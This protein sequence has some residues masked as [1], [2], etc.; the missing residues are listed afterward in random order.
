MDPRDAVSLSLDT[1]GRAVLFAGLIVVIALLG[2]F[3]MDLDFVRAVSASAIVAV[4]LT[5]TAA[6]TLLPALLGFAG[7]NID[8]FGLPHRMEKPGEMSH[9]LWWR[10][11]RVIQSYPWLSLILSASFL[12]MLTIPVLSMR[13]G[14][15][16]AGNRPETDTS[17]RAFD[18]LAEG[19]GPGFNAPIL[20]VVES[21]ETADQLQLAG[22]TAALADADG[23]VSVSA[24]IPVSE[25][26][27]II[28]VFG[29]FSPQ[30]VE[31]TDLVHRLRNETIPPLESADF[32][33]LTTGQ[34]P[35]VVDFAATWRRGYRCLSARCCC[36]LSSC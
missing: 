17:R 34:S 23:V 9:S 3:L 36:C 31:T 1:S 16:D 6:L 13:L 20:V 25:T 28:N 11:S 2:M 15:G 7:R 22:L 35:G 26:V 24:P 27:T 32:R 33:V 8:R 4:L 12:I 30:D 19:F 21:G 10:W 18:M 14:F 29:E 5:M